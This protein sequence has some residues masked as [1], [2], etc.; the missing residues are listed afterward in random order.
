MYTTDDHAPAFPLRKLPVARSRG[1]V[2]LATIGSLGDVFPFVAIGKILKARGFD[3]LLCVP[4]S[5]LD[6]V[7]SAGLDGVAIMPAFDEIWQAMGLT[8]AE[9]VRKIVEDQDFMIRDIA[10][11]A[12]EASLLPLKR[13]C[14]DADLIVASLFALAAPLV[15]EILDIPLIPALLQPMTLFSAYDPPIG[16]KFGTIATQGGNRWTR[17]WNRTCFGV[18]RTEMRRRYGRPINRIRRE[19]GL[20]PQRSTPILD[21]EVEPMLRLGLYPAFLAPSQPDFPANFVHTGFPAFDGT[22][23]T[24]LSREVEAFLSAGPA[25]LVFTL[26]SLVTGAPEKFY[27]ESIALARRL[28]MRALLLGSD[29]PAPK[30]KGICSIAYAPHSLIFPRA[31]AIVHHGGIGTTGQALRAARPQLIVPRLADQRDNG[32]RLERLGIGRV[33]S[34]KRYSAANAAPVVTALLEN[35]DVE[36]RAV[37]LGAELR[38]QNGAASAVDAIESAL[39]GSHASPQPSHLSMV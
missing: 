37:I 26:G 19:N 9:A 3:V 29:I 31:A 35:P 10:I 17:V 15:A 25:P 20:A 30:D 24:A 28:G 21:Q 6:M 2:V 27:G 16:Q 36:R 12:M 34:W 5:H 33:L 32:A 14:A 39:A 18:I 38:A 11:P 7:R 13:A 23:E 8:E 22:C 4:A 1:K